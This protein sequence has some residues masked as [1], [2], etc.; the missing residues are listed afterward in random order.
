MTLLR[1]AL[2]SCAVLLLAACS[3]SS[4]ETPQTQSGAFTVVNPSGDCA[5]E[6]NGDRAGYHSSAG[7]VWV[8]DCQNALARE[9][10]RVFATDSEH[11]Y[12]IPRPD[13]VA[14]LQSACEDPADPLHEIAQRYLLCASASSSAEADV[15]NR[16]SIADALTVARALHGALRFTYRTF[17]EPFAPPTD[18]LDACA[19]HPLD[20]APELAELCTREQRRLDS[21]NDIGFSYDGEGAIVLTRRLNE[22][23][24]ITDSVSL[25]CVT[26]PD[27]VCDRAAQCSTWSMRRVVCAGAC[28]E[29]GS[30]VRTYCVRGGTL[31]VRCWTEVATGDLFDDRG[32]GDPADGQNWRECSSAEK[33]AYAAA[34]R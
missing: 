14:P 12:I 13:G 9:Y 3:E 22:L 29:P 31:E 24:A 33:E 2:S 4:S 11:A 18:I 10:W 19:L 23:Y 7:T 6:G 27:L 26:Y 17:L 21:G 15:V 34:T 5:R 30:E 8:P 1:F 16:M 20:G 32:G 25:P 28:A